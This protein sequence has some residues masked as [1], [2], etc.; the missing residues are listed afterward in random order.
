MP[1]ILHL[2]FVCF[3][4]FF[5]ESPEEDANASYFSSLVFQLYRVPPGHNSFVLSF[6]F[7]PSALGLISVGGKHPQSPSEV[8]RSC[9][10]FSP[11]RTW[12]EAGYSASLTALGCA[13]GRRGAKLL[14]FCLPHLR[15][16]DVFWLTSSTKGRKSFGYLSGKKPT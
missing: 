10:C 8:K 15:K 14:Y 7:L 5:P 4:C 11:L 2:F 12:P 1:G 16:R 13:A 6:L 9:G 3:N